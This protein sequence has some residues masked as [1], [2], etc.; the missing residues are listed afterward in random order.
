M[1]QR[2]LKSIDFANVVILVFAFFGKINLSSHNLLGFFDGLMIFVICSIPYAPSRS[3]HYVDKVGGYHKV[4]ICIL[5]FPN[6]S[7]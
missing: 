1:V 7:P 6:A 2:P 3:N 5:N 4:L